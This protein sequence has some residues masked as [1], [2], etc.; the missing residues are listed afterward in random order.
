M[1]ASEIYEHYWEAHLSRLKSGFSLRVCCQLSEE[2]EAELDALNQPVRHFHSSWLLQ[3][4]KKFSKKP[5]QSS[6]CGSLKS[7]VQCCSLV[8]LRTDLAHWRVSCV[9]PCAGAFS[10][11]TLFTWKASCCHGAVPPTA[12]SSLLAFSTAEYMLCHSNTASDFLLLKTPYF[13]IVR[14]CLTWASSRRP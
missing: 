8:G 3:H 5:S 12:V 7:E 14:I 13:K 11:C 10:A 4:F 1:D 6:Y 2:G 9:M